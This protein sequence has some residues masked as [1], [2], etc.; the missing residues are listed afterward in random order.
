MKLSSRV[1]HVVTQINTVS[2]GG[3]V[4]NPCAVHDMIDMFY[5]THSTRRP[6]TALA[7][8]QPLCP[9]NPPWPPWEGIAVK[10]GSL[11]TD[12]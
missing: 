3:T 2:I 10:P 12:S 8:L 9:S 4:C 11:G 5:S 1:L 6:E 7:G